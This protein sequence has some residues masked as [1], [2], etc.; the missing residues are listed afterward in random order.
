MRYWPAP[1]VGLLGLLTGLAV[2]ALGSQE[3]RGLAGA[4][5][6]RPLAGCPACGRR[7]AAQGGGAP[8]HRTV[9]DPHRGHTPGA[10]LPLPHACA[11]G[12]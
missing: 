1:L 6:H 5:L 7:W 4:G 10:A 11:A 2:A 8:G 12:R 3:D 9:H